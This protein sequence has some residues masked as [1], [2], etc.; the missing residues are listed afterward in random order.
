[1]WLGLIAP[2][3]LFLILTLGSRQAEAGKLVPSHPRGCHAGICKNS[4]FVVPLQPG[5]WGHMPPLSLLPM[6]LRN[7]ESE[8]KL[9]SSKLYQHEDIINR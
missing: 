2:C 6:P 3:I 8:T 1:M 7:Q 9:T 4:A 5:A